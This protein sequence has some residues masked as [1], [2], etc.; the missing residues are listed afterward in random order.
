MI[1]PGR[2]SLGKFLLPKGCIISVYSLYADV[3][4]STAAKDQLSKV[5]EIA[6]KGPTPT[7]IA[8]DF[9][10]HPEEVEHTVKALAGTRNDLMLWIPPKPTYFSG[11]HTS[12]LDYMLIVNMPRALL[13]GFR[14]CLEVD[15][16]QHKAIEA[17]LGS[18]QVEEEFDVW[19]KGTRPHHM[20]VLG[21]HLP[22][23]HAPLLDP[24]SPD[25]DLNAPFEEWVD[26]ITP[27]F[28]STYGT[29]PSFALAFD[30]QKTPL[31]E[32]DAPRFRSKSTTSG[33]VTW[34]RRRMCEVRALWAS[35]PLKVA[36]YITNSYH[37]CHM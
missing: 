33:I 9:N 1:I 37:T 15:I 7:I 28:K 26:A 29:S 17:S 10:L 2:C 4:S 25:M 3:S 36:K 23:P 12:T 35:A 31:S 20:P 14:I 11:E 22:W 21:P 34:H 5:I 13:H 18:T 6:R 19:K 8:G 32:V 30:Y 24:C 27:N 16:G